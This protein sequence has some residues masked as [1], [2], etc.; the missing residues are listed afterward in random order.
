MRSITVYK[1]RQAKVDD[2]YVTFLSFLRKALGP[3]APRRPYHAPAICHRHGLVEDSGYG[4]IMISR[5][6]VSSLLPR[7]LEELGLSLPTVLRQA[8][9]P[10]GLFTGSEND[11]LFPHKCGLPLETRETEATPKLHQSAK[12]TASC[13]VD[14]K[15]TLCVR[16]PQNTTPLDWPE[17]NRWKLKFEHIGYTSLS[18]FQH[19]ET[20]IILSLHCGS[21]L[22]DAPVHEAVSM[23]RDG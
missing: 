8:N 18:P 21:F 4:L 13:L 15:S 22:Y 11:A 3:R 19:T 10:L 17:T 6:R 14:R 20:E 12:E 23:P 1:K 2:Y 5:F 16:Q 7:K 9:L